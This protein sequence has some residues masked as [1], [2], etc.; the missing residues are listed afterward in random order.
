MSDNKSYRNPGTILREARLSKNIS[1]EAASKH[2]RIHVNILKN[3]E[4]DDYQTLGTVY[5]KG[6]LKIYAEYLGVDR[7]EILKGFQ[8]L[9][10]SSEPLPARRARMPDEGDPMTGPVV[11]RKG[12]SLSVFLKKID[13]RLSVILVLIFLAV[14]GVVRL[15]RHPKP[16]T[17]PPP[18]ATGAKIEAGAPSSKALA[19]KT[20]LNPK[21]SEKKSPAAPSAAAPSVKRSTEK[22]VLVVR[23]K[24]KSWMQVKVDGKVVFQHVLARGTAETWQANEK[25]ELM[26]G[27]AGAVQLELNGRILE[28]IGRPRQT[29]KHVVV[30]REGLTI[31]S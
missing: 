26:I 8:D 11:V 2:T 24:S 20:V 15:A 31:G 4:N 3:I 16:V 1:L 25:I 21:A 9:T 27:D 17:A 14:L 28:K 13:Y 30:T 19:S 18:A 23:A 5:V 6:F 12:L 7:E 22:I 10:G 29:L